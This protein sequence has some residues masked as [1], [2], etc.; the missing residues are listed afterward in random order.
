MKIK[1]RNRFNIDYTVHPDKSRTI[2]LLIPE[3]FILT[4]PDLSRIFLISL[5]KESMDIV[6]R[7]R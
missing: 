6:S 5:R 7:V 3:V 4:S 1:K 2:L